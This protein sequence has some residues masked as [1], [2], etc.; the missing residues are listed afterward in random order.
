MPKQATRKSRDKQVLLHWPRWE[1]KDAEV[2][3]KVQRAKLKGRAVS[4]DSK[5]EGLGRKRG[6]GQGRQD[7]LLFDFLNCA[8]HVA[9]GVGGLGLGLTLAK[10]VSLQ[11]LCC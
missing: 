8:F 6:Q 5:E 4:H 9:S 11:N 3:M 7:I 1:E 10:K 2:R